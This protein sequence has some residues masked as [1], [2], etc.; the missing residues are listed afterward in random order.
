MLTNMNIKEL[1]L[2][3]IK[4]KRQIKS[5]D[6]IKATGFSRE[7][8]NRF[9]Q[10]LRDEGK[11]VLIGKS[12]ASRY[13]LADKKEIEK[14]KKEILEFK[15]D[16]KNLKFSE[17]DLVLKEIKRDAGIFID[18][19]KNIEDILEFSFLEM[20]NNAIEHS[21]SKEI[22]VFFSRDKKDIVFSIHDNGVGILNNIKTKKKLSGEMEA[23][24]FL[25]KGKQTTA[26]ETHTGQG[27]FFTSK[28]ADT[29]SISSYGKNLRFINN[30]DDVLVEDSKSQLKGTKVLF[31]IEINS[32][33]TTEKEFRKYT[34]EDFEFTKTKIVV[35]LYKI[36]TKFI[37][38]SEARR[39]VIGLDEFKE[40][41]LDFKDVETVGQ[42]F[43][44]EIFRVWQNK[45]IDIKIKYE[46]ANENIDFM[47]K[48]SKV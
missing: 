46:N 44:D 41:L 42:G 40:V 35:K 23:I 27:I 19:P 39:L 20:L 30:I 25:L 48:R 45:H 18:L 15:K 22:K 28:I 43:A 10:E 14:A 1:I 11:I 3:K 13:I 8:I 24:E 4:E 36:G 6:I 38:R 21:Q 26:P 7:Y 5:A 17:E 32:K 2:A 37:S 31:I 29:L 47:I 16:Y 12:S 9:L 34:D 33:R